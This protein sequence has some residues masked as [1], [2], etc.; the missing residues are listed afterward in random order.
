MLKSVS[1]MSVFA[2]AVLLP[3]RF[4]EATSR[5]PKKTSD[6]S[7][8]L[9]S[10][11]DD[12]YSSFLLDAENLLKGLLEILSPKNISSKR[13]RRGRTL[14]FHLDPVDGSQLVFA[15]L[16]LL[17]AGVMFA[18]FVDS[19]RVGI[20]YGFFPVVVKF[21]RFFPL[22][23]GHPLNVPGGIVYPPEGVTQPSSTTE[24]FRNAGFSN[25]F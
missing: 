12:A 21:N 9:M 14:V 2:V 18:L 22:E 15:S 6:V 1:W 7:D 19:V 16:M 25:T 24:T 11:L 3:T 8:Y 10:D 20:K 17:A 13:N 23:I 4:S 5:D